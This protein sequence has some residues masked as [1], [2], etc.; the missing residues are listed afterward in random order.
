M[1]NYP[2]I[3]RSGSGYADPEAVAVP[4]WWFQG[5][6]ALPKREI[7]EPVSGF[8]SDKTELPESAR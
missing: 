7:Y 2:A 8:I 3:R 6:T 4:P 1:G 5:G